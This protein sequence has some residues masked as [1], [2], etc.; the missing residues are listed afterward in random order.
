MQPEMVGL[1]GTIALVIM[2]FLGCPIWLV[3]FLTG[4]WGCVGVVG[5]SA[6]LNILATTPYHSIASFT[7][8]V[9]PLFLIMGEFAVHASMGQ[10]LYTAARTW[11]GRL[12][13]GLAMATAFGC[14]FFGMVTGVS[15]ASTTIFTKIALP[16]MR[17]AHYK[18]TV[19]TAVIASSGTLAVMIPPS[20]MMI[21]YCMITGASLGKLMLAGFIPGFL[22]ATAFSLL[23]YIW[24]RIDPAL[25]PVAKEKPTFIEMLK[26]LRWLG[27]VGLVA[28]L[29][30]GGIYVGVFSP[31]EAGAI[32]AFLTFV[33]ALARRSLSIEKLKKSLYET[34]R[35]TGMVFFIIVGG[36]IFGKFMALSG[37]T[38]MTFD[39]FTALAVPRIYVMILVM[40]GYLVLGCL[41]PANAMLVLTLPI[42]Y[43][44]LVDGFKYDPILLG[45][46]C[47][48]QVE[49]AAIT[50]P[51]GMGLFTVKAVAK[52]TRMGDII[53][54]I[55]PFFFMNLILLALFIAFPEIVTWL[56]DK[57]LKF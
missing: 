37:I 16:E 15:L 27:A 48:C 33:I 35:V 30:F 13:G 49:V 2:I 56:P 52:D 17:N 26:A 39:F 50:P 44:L 22:T 32:G 5:F 55:V 34:V 21:L 43:P 46:L 40:C 53:K 4:F 10:E 45:I 1:L 11:L 6:A 31:S 29:M 57:M 42:V 7:M 18:D 14:A 19:S 41:M 36:I 12:P 54:G 25:A 20:G 8:V 9:L 24:A 51:V 3:I 23:I 28:I 38:T 47:I